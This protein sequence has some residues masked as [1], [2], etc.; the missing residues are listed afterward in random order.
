MGSAVVTLNSAR[1]QVEVI[2]DMDEDLVH[3]FSMLA[4]RVDGA[5]LVDRLMGLQY[6]ESE[7]VRA[8]RAKNNH[9][10]TVDDFRRAEMIY[11]AITQS[12]NNTRKGFRRRGVS[13]R[14]Y[15][16]MSQS[17]LPEVHQR[18]Q[19][20]RVYQMDCVEVVRKVH[21]NPN[22]FVLLNMVLRQGVREISLTP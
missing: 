7:F 4:D 21:N 8:M 2:S 12:F 6:S 1:H 20:V 14:D 10:K 16:F 5:N 15:T 17:N 13:Q 18:L 11:I 19:G 9:Y 22:A 3:L